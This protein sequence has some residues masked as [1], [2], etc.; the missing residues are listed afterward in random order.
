MTKKTLV[1]ITETT[2]IVAEEV[3]ALKAMETSGE[4]YVIVYLTGGEWV[5]VPLSEDETVF[6]VAA[7]LFSFEADEDDAQR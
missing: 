3:T 5:D 7:R 4:R 1:Q 2:I 6:T